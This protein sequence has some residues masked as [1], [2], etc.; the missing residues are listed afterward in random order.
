MGQIARYAGS[1]KAMIYYSSF[2]DAYDFDIQ[3]LPDCVIQAGLQDCFVVGKLPRVTPV[4]IE[5]KAPA[6]SVRQASGFQHPEWL[7]LNTCKWNI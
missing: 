7:I 6:C 4:V 2:V 5:I 3:P 1:G